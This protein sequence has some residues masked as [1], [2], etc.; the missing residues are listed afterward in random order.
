MVSCVTNGL[1]HARHPTQIRTSYIGL[2]MFPHL[3]D[4]GWQVTSPSGSFS[5]ALEYGGS[6]RRIWMPN[7]SS[8][9]ARDSPFRAGL[10]DGFESGLTSDGSAAL[11]K[12]ERD[13]REKTWERPEGAG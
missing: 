2:G 1:K 3:A 8:T 10:R 5:A 9:P 11:G 6:N 12:P 4:L 13:G 7:T